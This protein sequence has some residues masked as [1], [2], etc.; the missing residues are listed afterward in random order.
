MPIGANGAM[1][2]GVRQDMVGYSEPVK[3]SLCNNLKCLHLSGKIA[4]FSV[5]RLVNKNILG[6]R[7]RVFASSRVLVSV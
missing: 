7:S 2:Y 5:V 6:R 1:P 3:H 4:S